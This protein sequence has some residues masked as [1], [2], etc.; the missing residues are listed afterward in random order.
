MAYAIAAPG[1]TGVIIPAE[2]LMRQRE[3][4]E[5]G[6]T[7]FALKHVRVTRALST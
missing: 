4:E 6:L 7:V 1:M 3:R 2:A 5:P